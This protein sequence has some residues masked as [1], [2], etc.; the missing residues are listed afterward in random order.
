MA[1]VMLVVSSYVVLVMARRSNVWHE[2]DL[3]M[4]EFVLSL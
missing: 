3:M 2:H 1:T 4:S